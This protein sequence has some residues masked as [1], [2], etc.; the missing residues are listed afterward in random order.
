MEILFK[1]AQK[2]KKRMEENFYTTGGR[3][4]EFQRDIDEVTRKYNGEAR[5]NKKE[6]IISE[7]L[8]KVTQEALSMKQDN[9]EQ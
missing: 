2:L 3:Q 1:H 6:E 5:G 9:T 7:F 4:Q 8:G